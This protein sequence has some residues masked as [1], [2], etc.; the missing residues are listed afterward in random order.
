MWDVTNTWDELLADSHYFETKVVIDGETFDQSQIINMASQYGMFSGDNPGVG[1]CLAGELS[2][3]MLDPGITFSRMALVEPYV[4]ATNGVEY[5]EWIPQGKFFIDT[6]ESTS[7]P[8]GLPAL[9]LH[10]YDGMLKTSSSYPNTT[11]QWPI[12]DL[13]VVNEIAA[14][15]GVGV[16][17][18]TETLV[19]RRYAVYLPVGLT[20]REVLE[21][22]ALMYAGNWIM[23]Y[24]GELLL[25]AISGVP[26]ETNYLVSH[27]YDTI[28]F[29]GDRILV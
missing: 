1:A 21:N 12:N 26:T 6:R 18:R 17:P 3:E 15:I 24:D 11:H 19:R 16:D 7:S 23:N 10:C 4:R 29:G 9:S 27:G 28:T 13:R 20:M 22:I 8:D 5:S 14:T 2:I 25:I